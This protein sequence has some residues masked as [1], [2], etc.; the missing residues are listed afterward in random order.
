M[1]L[2]PGII[3]DVSMCR[4][5]QGVEFRCSGVLRKLAV[6]AAQS[7]ITFAVAYPTLLVFSGVSTLIFLDFS[8]GK[9]LCAAVSAPKVG[10]PSLNKALSQ[11]IQS[12]VAF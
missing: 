7:R 12:D 2:N 8:L 5:K 6:T 10:G 1:V 3:P 9:P 4:G 11:E